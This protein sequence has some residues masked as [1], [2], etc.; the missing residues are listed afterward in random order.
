[1]LLISRMRSLFLF[2]LV[3]SSL[4]AWMEEGERRSLSN[5]RLESEVK[6]SSGE[7]TSTM[8]N[9]N[10][11]PKVS[12][13]FPSKKH[14]HGN[15]QFLVLIVLVVGGLVVGVMHHKKRQKKK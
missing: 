9:S 7:S 13:K 11:R 1:S 8:N 12:L 15:I 4:S 3:L 6:T 14:A 5:S 2:L 10:Y